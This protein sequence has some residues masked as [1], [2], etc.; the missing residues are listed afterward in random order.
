MKKSGFRNGDELI[1]INGYNIV[2]LT[3]PQEQKLLKANEWMYIIKRKGKLLKK[4][5]SRHLDQL[6][7]D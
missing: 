7:Y 6:I 5:V 4:T 1:S 3:S 2:R